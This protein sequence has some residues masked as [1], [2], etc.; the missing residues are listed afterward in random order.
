MF[1]IFV[2]GVFLLLLRFMKKFFF[3]GLLNMKTR[4]PDAKYYIGSPFLYSI[5]GWSEELDFSFVFFSNHLTFQVI[6]VIHLKNKNKK[7]IRFLFIFFQNNHSVV[8]EN[9]LPHGRLLKRSG[10][11]LL[12]LRICSGTTFGDRWRFRRPRLRAGLTISVF[13]SLA[14]GRHKGAG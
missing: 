12:R 13:Y 1:T 8:Q 9:S 11:P 5:M 7:V 10:S 4:K 6:N 2:S 3:W 14:A